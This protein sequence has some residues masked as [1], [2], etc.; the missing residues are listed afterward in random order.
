[1]GDGHNPPQGTTQGSPWVSQEAEEEGKIVNES[2]YFCFHEKKWARQG[3]TG[4]GLASLNNFSEF[5]GVRAVPSGAVLGPEI[6]VA[7]G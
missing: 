6:I 1:M 3:K 7:G 5:W 4:L 2:L